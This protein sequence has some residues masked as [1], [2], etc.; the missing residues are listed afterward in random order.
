M[1]QKTRGIVLHTVKFGESSLIVHT[2]T[3]RFGRQ[4]LMIKGVRKSRKQ[5]RSN[6]FQPLF[7]LDLEIYH[8]ES[9]DIHLIGNV[10]RSVPLNNIPYDH[11]LSTQALFMAE[12]LYRVLKEEESNPMLFHFLESSVQ[13]LDSLE[14]PSPDF[15][16]LFLFQLTKHL[17]FYPVNNYSDQ[18][19]YFDLIK[20]S[21]KPFLKDEMTQLSR[22]AG[23]LFSQFMGMEYHSLEV[24]RFNHHQR[25]QVL[26]ELLRFYRYH[27]EGMGEVRSAEVLTGLFE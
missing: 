27:N 6:L 4:S 1:L 15:H 10:S 23:N 17:G 25:N 26:R 20:G 11:V 7:L 8:K 5:S 3:E 19:P 13:Y 24:T 21:F 18:N 16:I 22:H 9:R 2:Y 12:V 14:E